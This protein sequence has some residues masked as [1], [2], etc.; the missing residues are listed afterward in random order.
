MM[1]TTCGRILSSTRW[2]TASTKAGSGAPGTDKFAGADCE[3]STVAAGIG[4]IGA[5][6]VGAEETGIE[7]VGAGDTGPGIVGAEATGAGVVGPDVT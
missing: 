4:A 6:R 7:I 3:L 1:S 2:T 5:G